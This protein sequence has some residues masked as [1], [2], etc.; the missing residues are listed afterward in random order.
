MIRH[1]LRL[2]GF[3]MNG[4]YKLAIQDPKLIGESMKEAL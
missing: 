2:F 1:S 4:T 3:K